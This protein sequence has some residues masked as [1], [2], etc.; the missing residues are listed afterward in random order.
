MKIGKMLAR[1]STFRKQ[2]KRALNLYFRPEAYSEKNFDDF[3]LSLI[4]GINFF[5][6][7]QSNKMAISLTTTENEFL[8]RNPEKG[9]VAKS[10]SKIK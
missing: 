4:S 3:A 7:F 1:N 10:I 8:K 5:K 9:K 6:I 2:L